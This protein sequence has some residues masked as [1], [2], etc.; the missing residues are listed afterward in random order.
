MANHSR[1]YLRARRHT[2]L[3]KKVAGTAAAPRMAVCRTLKHLYVQFI[4]DDTGR[5]L[6]A[7]STLDPELRSANLRSNVQGATSLGKAAAERARA[8]GIEKVVFD[9]GGFTYH[10]CVKAVGEAA[11]EAGLKF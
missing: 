6:A 8:A 2:R 1:R 9:R 10:G 11:R 3:R 7:V 4:D 5:T